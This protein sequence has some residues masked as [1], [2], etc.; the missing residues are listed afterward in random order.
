MID[1][2]IKDLLV[3]LYNNL[4]LSKTLIYINNSI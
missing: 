1:Y 3:L 4:D 2:Y